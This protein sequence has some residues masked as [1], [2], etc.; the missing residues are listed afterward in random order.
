MKKLRYLILS[1]ALLAAGYGCEDRLNTSPTDSVGS[2]QIFQSAESAL[3]AVNGIYRCMYMAD[4]GSSWRAENG[5]IMAYILASDL[6]GEDHIQNKA[7]S[8]WFYYDYSYGISS[9]YTYSYGRQGQCWNF[10]YTL[11]SNANN[12]IA[13]EGKIQDNPDIAD[14]VVGQAF[15]IRAY[16]YL[17]LVQNF[18]QCDASLPGVP[19]YTEPTTIEAKGKG[20]GTVQDVYDRINEDLEQALARLG[21]GSGGEQQ[22]LEQLHPSHIDFYVAQGIKARALLVQRDYQ[23]AASAAKIAMEKPGVHI[24][25]FPETT[26]INDVSKRNVMW[27]LAIQSDQS[28]NSNG[29]YAH[30]DADANTTYANG[31]QFLISSWLYNQIPPTD[32]RLA[33]WTAPMPESEWV[34]KSSKKSYVQVKMVHKE[35]SLG[36]GDYILMRV[37]EMALVVAEA[38]CHLGDYDTAREYVAM[39]TSMRDDHYEENLAS[40]PDGSEYNTNTVSTINNLMDYILLQRRIEL[41]GEVSRM[42]DLQRLGL[43]VDRTYSYPDNNHSSQKKFAAGDKRFIYAIPLGEFD[44]NMA[45]DPVKDQNPL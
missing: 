2:E 12:I 44:G 33:W 7:G 23:G 4:W 8:G 20:R 6:M 19:L 18:Q 9:D 35:A 28:L 30:I 25:P 27:G 43:G 39:V 13:N 15:A 1:A 42:H 40:V 21:G 22:P 31:A 10:F 26:K 14:Y 3:A 11:I 29:V 38:A 37:E 36:T 16:C 41:W 34:E 45:L 24:L 32:A 17:W 5:G